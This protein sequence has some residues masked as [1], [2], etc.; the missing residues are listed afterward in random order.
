[1]KHSHSFLKYYLK[2]KIKFRKTN[3]RFTKLFP[4]KTRFMIQ[5]INY[6]Y[7]QIY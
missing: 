4:T 5:A 1:M 7:D 3:L 2:L 6:D